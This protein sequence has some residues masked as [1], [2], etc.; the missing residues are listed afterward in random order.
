MY[1]IVELVNAVVKLF[2]LLNVVVLAPLKPFRFAVCTVPSIVITDKLEGV[3][4]NVLAFRV[5]PEPIFRLPDK[6]MAPDND[7]IPAFTMDKLA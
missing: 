5:L 1:S 2:V 4:T 3:I 7:F 6:P